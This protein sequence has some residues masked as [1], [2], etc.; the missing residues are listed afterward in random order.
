[1]QL[2]EE[3]NAAGWEFT[4]RADLRVV[5]Y[6]GAG[7]TSTLV[8]MAGARIYQRGLY[9]AFNKAI[10][11]EGGSK[12]GGTGVECRTAHSVAYRHVVGLGYSAE[13]MTG[14]INTRTLADVMLDCKDIAGKPISVRALSYHTRI[15]GID[16]ISS[17]VMA[18]LLLGTLRRFCQSGDDAVLPYHVPRPVKPIDDEAMELLRDYCSELANWIWYHQCQLDCPLP[19]GHDGYVK[20]WALQRP[21]LDR[22]YGVLMVDEAQDLNPVL[23]RVVADQHCQLV[24][25]GDSHQQ[26]YAWR[27]AVDALKQLRG[28]EMRLTQS[29]RFGS[30]IAGFANRLLKAMGETY[31]LRGNGRDDDDVVMDSSADLPDAIL[32]RTNARMIEDLAYY[33]G[34]TRIHIAG[35]TSELLRMMDDAERL[36]RGQPAQTSELLGFTQWHE[37]QEYSRSDE[38]ATLRTFVCMVDNHGV[39]KLRRLLGA[40][41]PHPELAELTLSTAHKAKGLE[42]PTVRISEDFLRTTSEKQSRVATLAERRLFYVAA[43]RAKQALIVASGVARPYLDDMTTEEVAAA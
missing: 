31:P 16:D 1:M 43:T 15:D 21:R 14:N 33:A 29:F 36:Q 17:T 10:A 8:A 7:K 4:Q 39:P 24:S 13:K 40:V 26:I 11:T 27:G 28:R 5:A 2:T 22:S 32:Y 34:Q 30:N 6:A 20:L 37:I 19:L 42:W 23:I 38:G 12:F 3:Q 9:L 35:G 41:E 25:V 18:Q